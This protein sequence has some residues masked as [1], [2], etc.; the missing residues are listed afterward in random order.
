MCQALPSGRALCTAMVVGLLNEWGICPSS[1][2]TV[3][4]AYSHSG[5]S[6]VRFQTHARTILQKI[7]LCRL[8]KTR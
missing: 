6:E 4:E 3:I 1:P 2:K 7:V 5:L 8:R